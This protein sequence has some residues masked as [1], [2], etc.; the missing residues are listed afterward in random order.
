VAGHGTA[1]DVNARPDADALLVA[2]ADYVTSSE[3]PSDLA[4]QTAR[5][6]LLDAL[7]CALLGLRFPACTRLLGPIVPGTVVPNG[8][9]VPG[10]PYLLDPVKAAFDLATA[11]RWLDYNDT[12]LAAL[13]P[14]RP[15]SLPPVHCGGGAAARRAYGRA[16][17]DATAADPRTDALRSLS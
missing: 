15:R 4:Y 9:H 2:I 1:A 14:G 6:A 3:V 12:W 5:Y 11:I 10:T 8:V 17:E 16:L 7:G 13:Q